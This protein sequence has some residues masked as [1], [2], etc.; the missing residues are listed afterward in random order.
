MQIHL[1]KIEITIKQRRKLSFKMSFGVNTI[2]FINLLYCRLSTAFL[3]NIYSLVNLPHRLTHT[4]HT[5]APNAEITAQLI[6]MK[7]QP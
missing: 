4:A 5:T 1:H 7:Y 3:S 6:I 2:H